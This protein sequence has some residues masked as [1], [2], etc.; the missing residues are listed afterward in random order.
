MNRPKETD[1]PYINRGFKEDGEYY[2]FV[3]E[4]YLEDLNIYIDH[5]QGE[6]YNRDEKIMKLNRLIDKICDE[7]ET[8]LKIANSEN[9][10]LK[11]ERDEFEKALDKACEFA[12]S[13]YGHS[14]A[15]NLKKSFMKEVQDE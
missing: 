3:N 7:L 5:L 2:L 10:K 4:K 9:K 1:H 14:S 6:L 13:F 11:Q 12:E 8:Q 15:E